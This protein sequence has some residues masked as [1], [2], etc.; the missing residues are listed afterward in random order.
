MIGG[1]AVKSITDSL[2]GIVDYAPIRTGSAWFDFKTNGTKLSAGILLAYSKNFGAG[3]DL[4]Y[5]KKSDPFTVLPINGTVPATI[6][7]PFFS[8][9]SNIDYLYRIAPRLIL[10]V[11]KLKLA[12]EI[13]YT[14]AAYGKIN[15]RGS[16]TDA[17]EVGNVRFLFGAYYYF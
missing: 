7:E 14:V 5:V 8:R 1:Y 15:P 16:V 11:S 13:D 3:T 4:C 10:M 9:G 2:R 12:A 17:K 6:A